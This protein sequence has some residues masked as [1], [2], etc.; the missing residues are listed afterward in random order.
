MVI[1][2]KRFTSRST[3][4]ELPSPMLISTK[5][6]CWLS[7][8]DVEEQLLNAFEGLQKHIL[9]GRMFAWIL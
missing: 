3:Q 4:L 1:T 5:G 7:R 6:K 9:E 2:Y 8:A